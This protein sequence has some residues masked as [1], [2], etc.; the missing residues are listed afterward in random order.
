MGVYRQ[1]TKKDN[2]DCTVTGLYKQY[3]DRSIRRVH[4]EMYTDITKTGVYS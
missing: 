4:I 3:T 1:Y 2:S